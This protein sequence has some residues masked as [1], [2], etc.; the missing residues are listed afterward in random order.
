V[1]FVLGVNVGVVV[2][3]CVVVF[4]RGMCK[5]GCGWGLPTLHFNPHPTSTHTFYITHYPHIHPKLRVSVGLVD[6]C[7]STSMFKGLPP[8][9]PHHLQY[10]SKPG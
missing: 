2:G 5:R 1:V 3:W 6:P 4:V 7:G 10:M 9:N 8:Q